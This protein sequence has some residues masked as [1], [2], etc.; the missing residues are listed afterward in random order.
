[1][2]IYI[3]GKQGDLN[4]INIPAIKGQDG[5]TP[6]IQVGDITTLEAGEQATVTRR[7]TDVNP[8]FDFGIPKGRDGGVLNNGSVMTE[9]LADGAVTAN[10]TSFL[11]VISQNYFD[12]PG[13]VIGE[14][15]KAPADGIYSTVVDELYM[16]SDFIPLIDTTT[17]IKIY[18][19]GRVAFFSEN[20]DYID[21]LG[22]YNGN[23]INVTIDMSNYPVLS[24][25]KYIKVCTSKEHLNLMYVEQGEIL[26]NGENDINF[27]GLRL[28]Q[29]Q[30]NQVF[31][32]ATDKSIPIS[33]LQ[34]INIEGGI[35][36]YSNGYKIAS[37]E[38][39]GYVAN[40]FKLVKNPQAATTDFI[41]ISASDKSIWIF[42]NIARISFFD[43]NKTYLDSL[44][45]SF[46]TD[47]RQHP[48]TT[49]INIFS[50]FVSLKNA[51]YVRLTIELENMENWSLLIDNVDHNNKD[52]SI[53]IPKLIVEKDNLSNEI[54]SELSDLSKFK[55]NSFKSYKDTSIVFKKN[56]DFNSTHFRIPFMC[57]TNLGT[58]IAGCDIRYKSWNDHSLI[59]IGTARSEDGGKTWIDKTVAIPNPGVNS[60][61]SRAMDGTI[62]ATKEGRVFLIGNKFNTG[63]T[64]WTNVTTPNDPN[65]DCVLYH[66][67]DDGRTWQ[68]NQSLKSL[69][70]EGQISFLGGVG[71]GIQMKDRTLVFP[72]QMARFNNNPFKCQSGIIYSRD[73]GV[74]WRMSE[75][76]V[77]E[78]TSECSVIEYPTGT[79]M[80]N[81]RQEGQN[82]RS[83]FKTT[84]LGTTWE[85][86]PMNTGTQQI[87][88]CQGHMCKVKVGFN[89]EVVLFTNPINDGT[90][91]ED[92]AKSGYDRSNL[93]LSI[94]QNDS[95]FTPIYTLYRP[96]SDGYSC[97]AFDERRNR[98]YVVMELEYNLVF[99]DVTDLLPTIQLYKNLEA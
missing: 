82:H 49:P 93:S 73:N 85:E 46:S 99:R 55:D 37:R 34:D 44:Y 50:S 64:G 76:L 71:S 10:K 15:I 14:K 86:T 24:S 77:P 51:K 16:I 52:M 87:N 42:N 7:G 8:I 12:N 68:L 62:L 97:I 54:K 66:S 61:L 25:A 75:S 5:I 33:S 30:I 96:H 92:G 59:D 26:L 81:C 39:S 21:A 35:L 72:I 80:I 32:N 27:K 38:D 53:S 48:P 91:R 90:N 41:S 74:T 45:D 69:L 56:E 13:T 9:Q 65:W 58:I 22:S 67:D 94:L 17:P 79:I 29:D 4:P 63:S 31:N 60:T 20:K 43:K 47:L 84:N 6:S 28:T 89:K 83:V 95:K 11:Q 98:L 36:K 3:R 57:V 1:M 70:P 40:T 78:Y 18:S 19:Y 88:T 23:S 2:A